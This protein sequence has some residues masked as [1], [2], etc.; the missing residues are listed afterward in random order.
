AVAILQQTDQRWLALI[1]DGTCSGRYNFVPRDHRDASVESHSGCD[2]TLPNFVRCEKSSGTDS[3]DRPTELFRKNGDQPLRRERRP[4]RDAE[5]R[6]H[7]RNVRLPGRRRD[8]Y[9]YARKRLK[10]ACGSG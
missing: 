3:R 8:S 10:A 9:H 4:G 6:W 5:K 7:W 1:M 2:R